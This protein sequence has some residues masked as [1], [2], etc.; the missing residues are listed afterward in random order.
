VKTQTLGRTALEIPPVCLGTYTLAG[1]W[2]GDL[3]QAKAAL[4]HGLEAGLGFLDTA[5]AYGRAER[6]LGEVYAAEMRDQRDR[7]IVCSKGGLDLRQREGAT[8][9]F[10]P[11]SRPEFLHRCVTDSLRRLGTDHLDIYLVHW[12]DPEVP[13]PEVAGAMRGLV[14]EGLVRYVGV[15]NYTP[16]QMDEF[17]GTT[18]IDVIQVPYSLFSRAVEADVLPYARKH[19]IGVMGYAALAQGYLTGTFGAEPTFPE[20]DFRNGAYDFSGDRYQARVAAAEKLA[21]F[22]DERGCTM[23][24]IAVAWV[25]SGDVPV[26]PLV[27]VQ[28][29]DHVDSI[30]RAATLQLTP[31]E[32]SS[33]RMVVEAAPEMD[34]AG[35]V[36]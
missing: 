35:L 2:S 26:V 23:P 14:D 31:E 20:G 11:N 27:G 24:E 30:L 13:I 5:H 4:R 22:A 28:A 15:S 33:L 1:A 9:P 34:F 17:L 21:V 25:A 36:S 19:E 8:T 29:P 7:V 18:P 32:V 10:V 12:Y 3:D 16:A 6:I